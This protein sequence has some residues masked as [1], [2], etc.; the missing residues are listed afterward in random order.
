[1]KS[2]PRMQSARK[3]VTDILASLEQTRVSCKTKEIVEAERQESPEMFM[4]DLLGG[5]RAKE[6][7][8]GREAGK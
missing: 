5:F 3:T 4:R 7:K 1:M 8:R 6:N 2:H